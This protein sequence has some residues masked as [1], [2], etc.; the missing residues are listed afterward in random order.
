MQKALGDNPSFDVSSLR[1]SALRNEAWQSVV[2]D[3][4]KAWAYSLQSMNLDLETIDTLSNGILNFQT[5]SQTDENPNNISGALALTQ[6]LRKDDTEISSISDSKENSLELEIL[7]T[8]DADA[9]YPGSKQTVQQRIDQLEAKIEKEGETDEK[10]QAFLREAEPAKV[11]AFIQVWNEK[12][13]NEALKGLD[14]G[15]GH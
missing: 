15:A 13:M 4:V 1:Q 2:K 14:D 9:H 8:V 10:M 5:A 7:G 6:A 3:P 12:G 11:E